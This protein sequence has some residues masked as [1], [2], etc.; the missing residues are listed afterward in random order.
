MGETYRIKLSNGYFIFQKKYCSIRIEANDLDTFVKLVK[1]CKQ[2]KEFQNE[3]NS[4]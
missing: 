3:D 4:E 1:H 2:L